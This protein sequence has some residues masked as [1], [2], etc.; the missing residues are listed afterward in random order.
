MADRKRS[1]EVDFLVDDRDKRKLKGIGDD[2][3]IAKRGFDNLKGAVGG[4]VAALGARA[5]AQFAVDAA[6]MAEQAAIAGESAEKVLG[7]ALEGLHSR[8]EDIRETLGL[9]IGEFDTIAAKFGLLT[10]SM[11]LSDEAQ[12]EFIGNLIE[13]GGE[14]AAFRGNVG[15]APAAIDAMGAALRGEF[16]PLEQ[17]GVKLSEAAVKEKMLELAADPATA[18]L[19]EQELRVMAVQELIDEKA[20][21]AI[22]SLAE[23]QDTLAGK[24]NEANVK[25]EDMKIKLG[26]K[27]LPVLA[28]GTEF[29]VAL[30][31]AMETGSHD[32]E[33]W[34]DTVI[35]GWTDLG[36][37]ILDVTEFIKTAFEWVDNLGD[38]IAE[39][40]QQW[41]SFNRVTSGGVNQGAG[42]GTTGNRNSSGSAGGGNRRAIGGDVQAGGLYQ[43]NERGQE[44]FVPNSAGTIVPAGGYGSTVKITINAGLGSDPNA[45]SKAVVEAL[46]RYQRQNGA[47]PISVRGG[48]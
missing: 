25:W 15:E 8:F 1:I 16:D 24:T 32:S 46:Q 27:L 11:G 17:F 29:I 34:I 9:N 5:L 31:D 7:P 13:T 23:A 14:L 36:H 22:G 4:V 28:E 20:A 39:A 12:A 18:S 6:Q 48:R 26:D 33:G 44:T 45:I 40:I 42:T 19:S 35:D 3:N 10:D 21:P 41:A 38:E 37:A 43:I 47:I 30:F 2:A